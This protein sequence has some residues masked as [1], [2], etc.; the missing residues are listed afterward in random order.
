MKNRVRQGAVLSPS[1][2]SL[3]LN[4]L[5]LQL[6]KS[7]YGCHVGNFFYGALA[8]ADDIAFDGAGGGRVIS[9]WNNKS[10]NKIAPEI[11]NIH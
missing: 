5:L 10:E 9:N 1:L 11:S 8:Y 7:G 6:E 2:F 4:S 3:Y